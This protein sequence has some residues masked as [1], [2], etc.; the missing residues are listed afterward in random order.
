M[1]ANFRKRIEEA[2]GSR[3]QYTK[4]YE[5]MGFHQDDKGNIVYREWAPSVQRAWLIGEFSMFGFSPGAFFVFSFLRSAF[6]VG[7]EINRTPVDQRAGMTQERGA[8]TSTI[9]RDINNPT[10]PDPVQFG[11][12]LLALPLFSYTSRL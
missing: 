1:Y 5:R 4:G 3:A 6:E 2:E 7:R 12:Q 8:T 11:C 9:G 10:S